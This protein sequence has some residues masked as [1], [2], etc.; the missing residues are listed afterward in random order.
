MTEVVADNLNPEFVTELKVDFKF[1]EQQRMLVQVY[2]ADDGTSLYDLT[3]QDFIGEFE[4]NLGKLVSS[5]DQEINGDL[6]NPNRKTPGKIKIM[7][8]EKKADSGK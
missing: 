8:N 4:F 6:T 5:R 1:E 3:K 7:A 2:D